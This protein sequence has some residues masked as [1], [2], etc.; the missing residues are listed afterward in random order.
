MSDSF[1]HGVADSVLG[2]DQIDDVGTLTEH[3]RSTGSGKLKA[4]VLMTVATTEA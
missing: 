1:D 2:L 3:L 4:H